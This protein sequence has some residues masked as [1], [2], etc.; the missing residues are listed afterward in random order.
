MYLPGSYT[1]VHQAFSASVVDFILGYIH[2]LF[3]FP[4][5]YVLKHFQEV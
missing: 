3:L 4:N 1:K 2:L 5:I